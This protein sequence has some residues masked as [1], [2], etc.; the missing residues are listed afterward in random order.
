MERL[1]LSGAFGDNWATCISVGEGGGVHT[2]ITSGGGD[3]DIF[4][5]VL[6]KACTRY[7]VASANLIGQ[8]M[9]SFL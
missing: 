1:W 4:E 8:S 3:T 6:Y 9:Y 5:P 2:S 7:A